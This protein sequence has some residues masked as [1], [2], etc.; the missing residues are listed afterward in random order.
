MF[1][2]VEG[3]SAAESRMP[4]PPLY[5]EV[6]KGFKEFA[7]SFFG[8]LSEFSITLEVAVVQNDRVLTYMTWQGRNAEGTELKAGAGDIYR[9]W[10]GKLA[11]H[12]DML[13][14]HEFE[15]FGIRRPEPACQPS[16]P[17]DRGGT[18]A[19]RANLERLLAYLGDVTVQDQSKAHL[20]IS[21]G[22]EQQHPDMVEPG[23]EGFKKC[24]SGFL[25]LAPD[26]TV[27]ADHVV[28]GSRIVGAIWTSYGHNPESGGKFILPTADVYRVEDGLYTKHW[29][30]IDYTDL[31]KLPGFNPADVLR[32][33]IG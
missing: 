10:N 5:G 29:G 27:A 19:Q 17:L 32:E 7:T 2:P 28:V 8:P 23:L 26:L 33:A 16:A 22:F 20:Y 18:P 15:P 4:R 13:E 12:W 24:F 31:I 9:V 11:E 14:Y 6:V 30:F 3:N 21:E 25:P 1:L